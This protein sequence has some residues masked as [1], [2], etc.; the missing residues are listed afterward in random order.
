[1]PVT[2]LILAL[3][4]RLAIAAIPFFAILS[5][6]SVMQLHHWRYGDSRDVSDFFVSS[7]L[8]SVASVES[9]T[10]LQIPFLAN[11]VK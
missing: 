3:S 10:S 11:S 8:R 1:M 9:A 6:V 5:A 4:S 2:D 7:K